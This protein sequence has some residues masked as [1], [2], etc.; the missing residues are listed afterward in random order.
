M[1]TVIAVWLSGGASPVPAGTIFNFSDNALG[2]G[3]RWDAVLTDDQSRRN[4]LRALAERRV[5]VFFSRRLPSLE[6][7]TDHHSDKRGKR[8]SLARAV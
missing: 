4:R 3:L 7:R 2:G 6:E 8:L 5:A 1:A